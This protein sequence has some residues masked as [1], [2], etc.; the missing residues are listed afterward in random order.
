MASSPQ[1]CGHRWERREISISS[2]L[3]WSYIERATDKL[4][5]R[6]FEKASIPERT[7]IRSVKSREMGNRYSGHMGDTLPLHE[8][9]HAAEGVSLIRWVSE[10]AFGECPV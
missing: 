9:R 3:T 10:M 5:G 2:W 4:G 7:P 6:F 8:E 1:P